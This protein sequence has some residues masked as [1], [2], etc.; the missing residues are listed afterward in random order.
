[1]RHPMGHPPPATAAFHPYPPHLEQ[2]DGHGVAGEGLEQI[3]SPFLERGEAP[4]AF[5][6]LERHGGATLRQPVSSPFLLLAP[7]SAGEGTP[8][9]HWAGLWGTPVPPQRRTHRKIPNPAGSSQRGGMAPGWEAG[10][11]QKTPP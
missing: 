9:G 2:L 11:S 10:A 7:A 5:E 6:E 3:Q 8:R 4:R 1:M